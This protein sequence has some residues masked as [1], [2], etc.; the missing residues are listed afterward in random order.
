[1]SVIVTAQPVADGVVGEKGAYEAYGSKVEEKGEV[2]EK[3]AEKGENGEV[4]DED[5]E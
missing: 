4:D 3:V 5:E 2:G 1:M